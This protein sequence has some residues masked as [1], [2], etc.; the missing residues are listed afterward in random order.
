MFDWTGGAIGGVLTLAPGR[1]LNISGSNRKDLGSGAVLNNQGT[2]TWTGPGTIYNY[3]LNGFDRATINNHDG[4]L[5]NIADDGQV[6]S[7]DYSQS[8]FNNLSGAR[9]SKSGGTNFSTINHFVFNSPGE[10]RVDVG[11][12]VF[13]SVATFGPDGNIAGGGRVRWAGD[14]RI[15]GNVASSAAVRLEG[16]TLTGQSGAT[17][18]GTGPLAWTAGTLA[19]TIALAPGSLVDISGAATKTLGSGAVVNN[20][21]TVNWSGPGVLYNYGLNGA[22]RATFNNLQGGTFNL[23]SDGPVFA[24]DYNPSFLNNSVGAKIRKTAGTG[25]SSVNYTF[26]NSGVVEVLAGTFHTS[27]T[28]ASST[29]SSELALAVGGL[30]PGTGFTRLTAAGN[31]PLA[32]TLTVALAGGFEPMTGATFPILNYGSRAGQFATLQLP[33]LSL[34]RV[35]KIDY[36]ATAMTLSVEQG[37][38]MSNAAR[39]GAGNFEFDLSGPAAS[40]YVI[41]ASTN[42]VNWIPIQTNSPFTGA[43]HFVDPAGTALPAR[44]YRVLIGP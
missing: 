33:A 3:G 28:Y 8:T 29:A 27:G 37:I 13:D 10:V 11:D 40:G 21:G 31:L 38:A 14:I 6:F 18:G 35:W 44:F 20:Q 15:S 22:D 24:Y 23:A 36:G 5:F 30:Q 32:G 1:R 19:G 7:H 26:A 9:F 25:V 42:L 12:L 4:G 17:Y 41:Q 43:F 39:N 2:I 16:G 34:G